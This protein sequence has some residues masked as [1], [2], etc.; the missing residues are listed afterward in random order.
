MTQ[1]AVADAVYRFRAVRSP[2][3]TIE[4]DPEPMVQQQFARLQFFRRAV[5][6]AGARVLDWGCGSGF[7]CDWLAREG[8][9]AEVLGFDVCAGAVELARRS[10][11]GPRFAV[12][13]GCDPALSLSPGSWDRILSC[14]VLE[15]V[16]DMETFVA[17]IRRHL[18]PDG[19]AFLSTPNRLVFSLGFE[20]SPVN[21]E[22]VKELTL[23]E[24]LALL[25]PHFGHV[26]VYGQRFR[27]PALLE[28]WRAD[29]RR[30]IESCR[31]G[32]RWAEPE[33]LRA[34]LLRKSAVRWAYEVPALRAAWRAVRWE[35]GGR[36]GAM[37][38]TRRPPYVWRDFEF[39]P[40]DE[41]DAV[42]FCALL[43]P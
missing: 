5:G 32:D 8:G 28:A 34:R 2:Y 1:A 13:D 35:L 41:A 18:A 25:R 17:N 39:V 37:L 30:K 26:E 23:E 27:D 4:N 3:A 43:R 33:P 21:R 19:V 31:R 7:N 22:H 40:A 15:H 6:A 20:P 24:L 16:P 10:F 9:A 12:E 36:L 14:E 11:P 38:K 42:W 29:V